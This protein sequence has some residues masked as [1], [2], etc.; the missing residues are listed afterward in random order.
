[1]RFAEYM[2]VWIGAL[3]ERC[4]V[5]V[6]N[7]D[8]NH[9]EI[10]PLGSKRGE[11]ENENM[12]KIITWYIAERLQNND[13]VDVDPDSQMLKKIDVEG[14]SILLSHDTDAKSLEAAA[15]QAVL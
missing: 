9:T 12:E 15:K 10:R 5:R 7:V 1:M 13:R 4:H 8:G 6:Y 2:S 14:F 11:Y 3:S